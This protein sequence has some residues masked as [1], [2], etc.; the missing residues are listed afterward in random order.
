MSS[1]NAND[2]DFTTE[3]DTLLNK[4]TDPND[5]EPEAPTSLIGRSFFLICHW[6][7]TFKNLLF[8][9]QL[10]LP[11]FVKKQELYIF[12]FLNFFFFLS[13]ICSTIIGK[14]ST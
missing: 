9:C 13:P 11:S 4:A 12:F 1:V 7:Y 10:P 2:S 6:I 5:S 14:S 8:A 3:S